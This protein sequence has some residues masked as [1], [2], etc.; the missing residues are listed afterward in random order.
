MGHSEHKPLPQAGEHAW[1]EHEGGV[2]V[3]I[4]EFRDQN[5]LRLLSASFYNFLDHPSKGRAVMAGSAQSWPARESCALILPFYTNFPGLHA[6]C[7][8]ENVGPL[9]MENAEANVTIR[10]CQ[11]ATEQALGRHRLHQRHPAQDAATWANLCSL[12][13]AV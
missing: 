10:L 9:T 2:P 6:T 5:K 4:L 8:A 1:C 12:R 13:V 11:Q 7:I 3:G